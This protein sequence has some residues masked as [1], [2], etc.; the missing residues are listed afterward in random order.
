MVSTRALRARSR[1]WA[2]P[3]VHQQQPRF[4]YLELG[5]KLNK[6][7]RPQTEEAGGI[8]IIMVGPA[9]AAIEARQSAAARIAALPGVRRISGRPCGALRS[10]GAR[11]RG[12]ATQ[13]H[14]NG[15][16]VTAS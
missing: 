10:A 5:A 6:E 3:R 12:A 15:L 8:Q 11:F 16:T 9:A 13:A 14:T 2:R 1:H 7:I 4:G